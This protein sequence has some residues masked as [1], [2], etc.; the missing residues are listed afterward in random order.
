MSPSE[1]TL[2]MAALAIF[3]AAASNTLVKAGI[4]VVAGGWSFGWRVLAA[5]L[6][7][8]AAGTIAAVVRL[9]KPG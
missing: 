8:I 6:G 5:F 1:L 9:M 2:P 3:I 4:A 7:M